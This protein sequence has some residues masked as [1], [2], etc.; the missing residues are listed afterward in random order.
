MGR[1][2]DRN[3]EVEDAK[4]NASKRAAQRLLERY[5]KRLEQLDRWIED[6]PDGETWITAIT[7]KTA[8]GY[9]GGVMGMIKATVGKDNR[10]AFHGAETLGECLTGIVGRLDNGTLKWKEDKPYGER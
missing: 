5:G 4:Y 2:S 8:S 6:P 3:E 10:I 7:F 1:A 9:D